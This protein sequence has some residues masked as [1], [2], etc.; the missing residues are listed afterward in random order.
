[1]GSGRGAGKTFPSRNVARDPHL[2]GLRGNADDAHRVECDNVNRAV[3]IDVG[4][5]YRRNIHRPCQI[6]DT[7]E[8]AVLAVDVDVQATRRV[9]EN[10]IWVGIAIEIGPCERTHVECL[11]KQLLRLPGDVA[12][13][14]QYDGQSFADGDDKVDI[15]IHL[16]I[17][18]PDADT[19]HNLDSAGGLA[20]VAKG[21]S[22][23]LEIEQHAAGSA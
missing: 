7:G 6:G 19:I 1:M 14:S 9:N 13:V 12:V 17:C 18:R 22:L 10:G 8:H 16:D 11:V 5:G 4:H 21:T 20:H 2:A 23:V 3:R 15:T